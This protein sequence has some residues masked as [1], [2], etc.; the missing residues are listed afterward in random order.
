[1]TSAWTGRVLDGIAEIDAAQWNALAGAEPSPFIRWEWIQAFEASGSASEDTGWLPHHLTLWDSG[2]LVAAAPAYLKFHSMGEYVYDFAWAHAA[3]RMGIPYYPK[4]L[5]AVPLSPATAPRFLVAPGVDRTRAR[6]Q[7]MAMAVELAR[8]QDASSVHVLYPP[9]EDAEALEALGFARRLTEQFHWKNPG[10]ASWEAFLGRFNSKRRHQLRRERAAAAEQGIVLRTVRGDALT[11][12][13]AALGWR[14]Y[15]TTNLKHPW[16][17][18]QLNEAFFEQVV[19]ALPQHVEVVEAVRG[20]KVIAGA[21][22]LAHAGRLYGRYWGCFEEHPF[23]H[24]NVCMYHSIDECIRLGRT[25]FEPGAG[26][27]HKVARGFEPTAV[28]SAHL[29][30]DP[31]LDAA[32]RAFLRRESAALR[33]DFDNAEAIAG[34]KPLPST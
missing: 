3:E 10:Y 33:E 18:I 7:L 26:G 8:A 23:L 27:E 13:H 30:F 5:L 9:E 32:V 25:V 21:F 16:G 19:K 15:E 20:G 28:H 6:R 34:L 17:N 11:P 29:L 22:N 31:R 24:F 14:L 1:M 12:E 2:R 4:L